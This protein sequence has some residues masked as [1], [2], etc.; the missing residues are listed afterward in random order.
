MPG[1][2]PTVVQ[3]YPGGRPARLNLD[4]RLNVRTET[5]VGQGWERAEFGNP[6]ADREDAVGE[7][8][9]I[10]Q[11]SADA[12]VDVLVSY[13]TPQLGVRGVFKLIVNE[14]YLPGVSLKEGFHE[15]F[16]DNLRLAVLKPLKNPRVF[17]FNF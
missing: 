16:S 2:S 6:T 3:P 5:T 15:I 10:Q 4:R 14:K 1:F 7:A 8:Y 11:W 13:D 9:R 12:A 17:F